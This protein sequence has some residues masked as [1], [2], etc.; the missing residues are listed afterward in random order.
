MERSLPDKSVLRRKGACA[1]LAAVATMG[2][3]AVVSCL[4]ATQIDLHVTTNAKCTDKSQWKGVSIYVGSP[5]DVESKAPALTTTACAGNGQV[6]SLVLVPTGSDSDEVGIRVVAGVAR[7]PEECAANLYAGCIVARRSL[8]YSPHQSLDLY[9]ALTD[10]CVGISCD[11]THTCVGGTCVD[12]QSASAGPSGGSGDAGR[13]TVRC[14]D[15]GL[16]CPTSGQVCCLSVDVDAGTTF[17]QCK[18]P[19]T[20][21][22]TSMVLNCDKE[23]DCAGPRDDAGEPSLCCLSYTVG[24]GNGNEPDYISG[25]QCLPYASCTRTFSNELCMDRQ[26]C[27]DGTRPCQASSTVPPGL[28]P[29]YFWCPITPFP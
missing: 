29:G 20:C 19:S 26:S 27:L 8:R 28:M 17:G 7:D 25:L 4:G 1:A 10:D 5:A 24:A 3:G 12:S 13:G 6:G 14:G 11:S 22:P 2:G 15:N 9:V 18:D 16:F 23:R 21:P